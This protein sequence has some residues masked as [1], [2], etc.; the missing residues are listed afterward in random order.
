LFRP[1]LRFGKSESGKH[2]YRVA[3][4]ARVSRLLLLAGRFYS[5]FAESPLQ[6]GLAA[7]RGR[8]R[9]IHNLARTKMD[10]RWWLSRC[11]I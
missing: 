9:A 11:P 3:D 8:G 4:E 1:A 5:Q 7:R 6:D 2:Y 10:F